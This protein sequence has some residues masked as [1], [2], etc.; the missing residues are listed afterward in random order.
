MSKSEED[1]QA[2]Y[3]NERAAA[4]RL[5]S[6]NSCGRWLIFDS[7]IRLMSVQEGRDICIK[8]YLKGFNSSC[9][10]EKHALHVHEFGDLG[11]QCS[12]A[13]GHFNPTNSTHGGPDD[14]E[15]Q[16]RG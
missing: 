15:R 7:I 9:T 4:M 13:G 8:V 14:V 10:A 3:E 5:F 11:N 16:G 6:P 12:N 1:Q 2:H